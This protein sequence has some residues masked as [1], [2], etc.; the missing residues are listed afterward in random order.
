MKFARKKNRNKKVFKKNKK[1]C[2][3]R[4]NNIDVIDYKD[5]DTIKNFIMPVGKIMPG[6]I[7][8]VSAKYQ[9]KLAKAIKLARIMGLLPYVYR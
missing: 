5:V 7:T 6:R 3:F 9:R 4:K 8:K 2:F 1:K